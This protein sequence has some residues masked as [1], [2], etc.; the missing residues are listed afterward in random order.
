MGYPRCPAGAGCLQRS[1]IRH[2]L[3]PG[4]VPRIFRLPRT[5][6]IPPRNIHRQAAVL[7]VRVPM[8]P[9]SRIP[10]F[11]PTVGGAKSSGFSLIELLV[12]IG[13]IGTLV[14][15]LLPSLQRVREAAR[16]SACGNN[17]RQSALATLAYESA[18]RRFPAGCDQRA[19]G[20]DLPSGTL[21]AW[22][23]FV[24][25]FIEEGQNAGRIDYRRFWNASGGNEQASKQQ[26]PSYI[27]PSALLTYVG[28]ADYGGVA[29]AWM[30]GV[31]GVPFLGPTGLTSGMLVPVDD[32]TA[33]VTAAS[34]TDG[35]G[36]TLLIAESVDRGLSA[37]PDTDPE[38]PAGRWAPHNCFAQAAA[39]VNGDTSDIRSPHA[40]GAQGAF[41]DG[42]VAFLEETMDPIVLAALCTRNGGDSA[43]RMP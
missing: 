16:R 12:V 1:G 40:G 4:P 25:P 29:G 18:K 42:R 37:G 14:G 28:K 22:S 30:L 41:A 3:D 38:D 32:A 19:A 5:V 43:R 8:I 6:A 20:P 36:T 13:I 21:H 9:A 10:H 7:T 17:L 39:F 35:L 34:A 31:E 24:L 23:S 2:S 15:L 26:V 33:T 27:C 11:R